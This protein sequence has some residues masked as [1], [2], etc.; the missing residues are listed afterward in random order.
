M[1]LPKRLTLVFVL[2][3]TWGS[4][5]FAQ[6]GVKCKLFSTKGPLVLDSLTVDPS[7]ININPE[8]DYTWMPDGKLRLDYTNVSSI[9]NKIDSVQIC[10][11]TL[12]FKLD[13]SVT[14][15]DLNLK[16][17]V[18]IFPT[19]NNDIEVR[20]EL[21]SSPGIE[22]SG[23]LSRGISLG[24]R[25]D[26]FVNSNL[27]LQMHGELADG[28]KL[29]AVIS[30]QNIPFQPEGNTQQ[31]QEFDQ[32][33]INLDHENWNLKAGDVLLQSRPSTFMKYF[34]KVQGVHF[35]LNT[36]KDTS[37]NRT[38]STYV[39]GALAKGKFNTMLLTQLEGVQGPYRLSGANGEQFIIIVANT[40]KV[41]L[42]GKELKRG[43]DFDYVIDYNSAEVTFNNSIVITKF[44]RIRVDFEYTERNYARSV[45]SFGH[46]QESRVKGFKIGLDFFNERDNRRQYLQGELPKNQQIKLSEIGD[47]IQN[48]FVPSGIIATPEAQGRILY[49]KLDTLGETIFLY[50][51]AANVNSN[52]TSLFLVEFTEVGT[53]NGAY[54]KEITTVNGRVF[55][56]VGNGLGNFR[57][58]SIIPPPNKREMVLLSVSKKAGKNG[59]FSSET[60][61][62][63]RDVNLFSTID[64]QDDQG[65][66]FKLQYA[67]KKIKLKDS[68]NWL[69]TNANY[70]YQGLRFNPLDRI[71]NVDFERDWN[72]T[73]TDKAE[74][75]LANFE[76]GIRTKKDQP[77]TYKVSYRNK[78]GFV[79]G[80]QQ[81]LDIQKK[82]FKVLQIK[83]KMFFMDNNSSTRAAQWRRVFFDA[84]IIKHKK[85]RPGYQFNMDKNRIVENDSV[86]KP[87]MN[88]D[89]H[90]F[91]IKGGDSLGGKLT[92]EHRIRK[93][94]LPINNELGWFNMP[95]NDYAQTSTLKYAGKIGKT[96]D[97]KLSG[98]FRT[99]STKLPVGSSST[100]TSENNLLGRFDW[101]LRSKNRAVVSNFVYVVN[102]SRELIRE[103]QY[104]PVL[105]SQGTH[106]WIDYNGNGLKDLD[107]FQQVVDGVSAGADTLYAK[108]FF[109]TNNYIK[110][111]S[112]GLN[113]RLNLKAP[114]NWRRKHGLK[115]LFSRFDN[116]NFLIIDKKTT[117]NDLNE[118]LNP[119]SSTVSFD[120]LDENVVS[121]KRNIRSTLFFNRTNPVFGV[122]VSRVIQGAKQLLT[123]GQDGRYLNEWRL[124]TRTLIRKK[125]T[126]KT[127]GNLFL[128][129]SRSNY[130][131]S[132]EYEINGFETGTKI[133]F[134]PRKS[135]RVTGGF[136]YGSKKGKS[137]LINPTAEIY[138]GNLELKIRK[139]S[140]TSF[141]ILVRYVNIQFSSEAL[142]GAQSPLGYDLLQ[143][144]MPGNNYL[145][146]FSMQ[147]RL[148]NGLN[149]NLL[150]DGRRAT[151]GQTVHTGSMQVSALF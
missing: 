26:V 95:W 138:E 53:G 33:F 132:R 2:V 135:T 47:S 101:N 5:I 143:A 59:L 126:V 12:P 98:S 112:H 148:S 88:Y 111:F 90:V 49:E 75:H 23:V 106:I 145:W 116:T 43:F 60:A 48:A 142:E 140:K 151:N 18:F 102:T 28:I 119:F 92:M 54:I 31:I 134:Q 117:D 35:N 7:T 93:D 68:N 91:Y 16:D 100:D 141:T 114:G 19:G 149:V 44:S 118:R 57:P 30:D 24:N 125:I 40:E 56:W 115:K 17:T 74:E 15:Y 97:F 21:F 150:Y 39:S 85:I 103:L 139:L 137:V 87:L 130:L 63:T 122:D 129:E 110:A 123:Y 51:N 36:G 79:N 46:H 108:F 99:L 72:T 22:K 69:V 84:A 8:V 104:I 78:K 58:V 144:L 62:S 127:E 67:N 38:S 1:D 131:T 42:D 37:L 27:N 71:R 45:Y 76:L 66:A 25:Q 94:Y 41:F 70:Q 61:I 14:K 73:S 113:Y 89:E 147:R 120:A 105:Q 96:Q 81:N 83:S 133:A 64:D 29:N 136:E 109:P 50:N 128:K 9:D 3:F 11:R 13:Q 80:I 121:L 86:L 20:E 32:I 10:Y 34:K 52:D 107:E 146:K 124:N 4:G 82:V 77:L 6:S 65:L 55:K